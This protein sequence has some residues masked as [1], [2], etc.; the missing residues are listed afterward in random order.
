MDLRR[1]GRRFKTRRVGEN[2][3]RLFLLRRLLVIPRKVAP[4]GRRRV[5]RGQVIARVRGSRRSSVGSS[6]LWLPVR[7]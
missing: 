4:Q 3:Q 7:T 2:L 1:A 6:D 5:E